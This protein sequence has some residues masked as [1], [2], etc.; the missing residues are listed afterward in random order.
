MKIL[1]VPPYHLEK[2][3]NVRPVPTDMVARAKPPR[4]EYTAPEHFPV[5]ALVGVH[6]SVLV[7]RHLNQIF[8]EN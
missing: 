4:P 3:A 6:S 5:A 2:I 7:V 8:S 1:L